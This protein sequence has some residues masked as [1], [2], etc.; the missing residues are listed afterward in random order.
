MSRKDM[1]SES[2]IAFVKG[3]QPE[4]PENPEAARLEEI[5]LANPRYKTVRFTVDL[6]ESLHKELRLIASQ[7]DVNMSDIARIAIK[8]TIRRLKR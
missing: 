7:E 4:N 6:P 3:I 2:E 8:E 1:M 5:K